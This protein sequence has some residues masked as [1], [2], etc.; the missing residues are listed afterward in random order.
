MV[1]SMGGNVVDDGEVVDVKHVASKVED[2][3]DNG[4]MTCGAKVS[5]VGVEYSSGMKVS[6][7]GGGGGGG[8]GE[9]RGCWYE[10][11]G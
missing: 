11:L 6:G 9:G 4:G 8:G 3:S 7:G 5:G 1:S 10:I 2:V